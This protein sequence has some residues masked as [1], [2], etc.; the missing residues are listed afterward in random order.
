MYQMEKTAV[1]N[2]I[3]CGEE[4]EWIERARAGDLAAFD[5]LIRRHQDQVYSVAYR[6]LGNEDDA[7]DVAQD[8]FLACFRHLHSYRGASKFST[9][10]HRIAVNTVKNLWSRRKR[11]KQNQTDSLDTPET[12]DDC[13]P[14]ELLTDPAPNPRQLAAGGE[15]MAL[16]EKRLLE[17]EPSF[18]EVIVL[19]F[20]EGM[21]YEEIAEMTEEPLGTIKSRIFRARRLLSELMK[22]YLE[23]A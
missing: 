17:L 7:A 9:W 11:Q 1:V 15:L 2:R 4:Q 12:P 8:V 5:Q 21:S 20:I 16:L 19:R 10:L 18:R 23:E 6:M 14:I 13:A 22:D 3:E